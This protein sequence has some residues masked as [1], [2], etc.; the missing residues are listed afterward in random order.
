M[1]L[2]HILSLLKVLKIY[3]YISKKNQVDDLVIAEATAGLFAKYS[4]R[5]I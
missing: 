3:R 5:E 2:T 1:H 4:E